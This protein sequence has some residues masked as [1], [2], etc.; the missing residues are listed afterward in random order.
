LLINDILT[1]SAEL[2]KPV[3]GEKTTLEVAPS[4][5]VINLIFGGKTFFV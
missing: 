4:A 3:I 1:E 2:G 5:G